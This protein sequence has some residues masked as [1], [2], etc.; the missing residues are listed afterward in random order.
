[1]FGKLMKEKSKST[2]WNGFA[3]LLHTRKF[4][5]SSLIKKT[6]ISRFFLFYFEIFPFYSAHI[7]FQYEFLS[8]LQLHYS[9]TWAYFDNSRSIYRK[10]PLTS[11]TSLLSSHVLFYDPSRQNEV[12]LPLHRLFS[13]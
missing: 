6:K 5:R 12:R 13:Q 10:L 3:E 2:F 11:K 4:V 7:T 1:M 9:N 8:V